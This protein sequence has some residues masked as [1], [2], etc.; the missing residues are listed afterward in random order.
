[1][2][3]KTEAFKLIYEI[4]EKG[5]WRRKIKVYTTERIVH[6]PHYKVKPWFEEMEKKIGVWRKI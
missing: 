1:M 2:E 5:W 6:C 3:E 4:E